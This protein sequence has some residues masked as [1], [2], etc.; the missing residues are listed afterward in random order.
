MTDEP[1][2]DIQTGRRFFFHHAMATSFLTPK[3]AFS[4]ASGDIVVIG[5]QIV[6]WDTN[7]ISR[8]V[9]LKYASSD[10]LEKNRTMIDF[11]Y[12]SDAIY[13]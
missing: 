4:A 12:G 5:K 2:M 13:Q 1:S 7:Y 3:K 11:K 6:A 9:A 10:F 8:F